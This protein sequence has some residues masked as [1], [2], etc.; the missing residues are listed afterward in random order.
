VSETCLTYAY[1][2]YDLGRTLRLAGRPGVAVP[3]LERRLQISDQRAT[4]EGELALAR[5]E[6]GTPPSN[7]STTG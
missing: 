4:V 5:R 1:A 7:T 2:L 6:A 3:V